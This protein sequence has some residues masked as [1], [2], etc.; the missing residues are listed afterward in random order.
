MLRQILDAFM[1][2]SSQSQNLTLSTYGLV[3]AAVAASLS[4]T[5]ADAGQYMSS[6]VMQTFTSSK[7]GEF[8]QACRQI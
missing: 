4:T 7:Q 8:D 2:R 3:T 1:S 6:L 5:S